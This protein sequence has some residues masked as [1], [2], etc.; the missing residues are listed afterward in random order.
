M[1]NM[2][3]CIWATIN[4]GSCTRK[5]VDCKENKEQHGSVWSTGPPYLGRKAMASGALR[6]GLGRPCL[7][8]LGPITAPLQPTGN[9]NSGLD[10]LHG[11]QLTS[12]DNFPTQPAPSESSLP[13][14]TPHGRLHLKEEATFL[15]Q[16]SWNFCPRPD[17]DHPNK[18]LE[19]ALA[20]QWAHGRAVHK[21]VFSE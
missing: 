3:D 4:V 21:H 1:Q 8:P 15:P 19:T 12:L 7:S 6:P 20:Q 2:S 10:C 17:P 11:L 13:L 18:H 5:I 9:P 14:R 16:T